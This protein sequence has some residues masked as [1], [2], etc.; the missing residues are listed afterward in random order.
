M[1]F[2]LM[3]QILLKREV[4]VYKLDTFLGV[5][6]HTPGLGL[7]GSSEDNLS[8]YNVFFAKLKPGEVVLVVEE[9]S[10]DV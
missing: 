1:S 6:F 4:T 2:N 9:S 10:S 8:T 3:A 7:G 5:V